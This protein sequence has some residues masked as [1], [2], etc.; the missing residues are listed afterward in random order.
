MV[1]LIQIGQLKCVFV[2]IRLLEKEFQV[3]K[4]AAESEHNSL[5]DRCA[6]LEATMEALSHHNQQLEE[7]LDQIRDVSEERI[8]E[9]VPVMTTIRDSC[10][11]PILVGTSSVGTPTL[12]SFTT[13]N[14]DHPTS[15]RG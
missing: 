8:R 11:Q 7:E 9:T 2:I 13:T 12:P 5:E 15:T 6:D 1:K 14:N 4:V 3:W 10:K